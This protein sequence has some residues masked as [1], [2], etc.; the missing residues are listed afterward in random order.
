MLHLLANSTFSKKGKA[1]T[2]KDAGLET[3]LLNWAQEEGIIG[4]FFL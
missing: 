1:V 4:S 2:L 3:I